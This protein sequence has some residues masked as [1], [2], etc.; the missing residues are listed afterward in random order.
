MRNRSRDSHWKL[1][2]EETEAFTKV[3]VSMIGAGLLLHAGGRELLGD[4]RNETLQP[5]EEGT[6][7]GP[8]AKK[9]AGRGKVTSFG[10]GVRAAACWAGD[11]AIPAHR[12]GPP[13][14]GCTGSAQPRHCGPSV[15]IFNATKR[16]KHGN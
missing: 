12:A 9:Q 7:T 14:E 15:S 16:I 3:Q 8:W 4:A 6:G 13:W 11:L 5:E 2:L 10:G 1:S